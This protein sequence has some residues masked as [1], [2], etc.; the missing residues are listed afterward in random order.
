MSSTWDRVIV[1]TLQDDELEYFLWWIG[2]YTTFNVS[3][4]MGDLLLIEGGKEREWKEIKLLFPKVQLAAD[5]NFV[6][7]GIQNFNFSNK[8]FF[9]FFVFHFLC[10]SFSLFFIFFVFHFLCFSFSLFFIF[11]KKMKNYF[12]DIIP[13]FSG[14]LYHKFSIRILC[15]WVKL[16]DSEIILAPPT[17]PDVIVGIIPN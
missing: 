4:M 6:P 3:M 13:N 15:F 7:V 14:L 10:F 11:S 8:D 17:P 12:G 5:Y 16:H 9:I 1:D 2:E